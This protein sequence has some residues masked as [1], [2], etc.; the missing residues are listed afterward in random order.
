MLG[1]FGIPEKRDGNPFGEDLSIVQRVAVLGTE[2]NRLQN[3]VNNLART[4]GMPERGN[5]DPVQVEEFGR[6]I[7]EEV[8]AGRALTQQITSALQPIM[9]WYQS[10][11]Q[12]LRPLPDI[13]ADVVGDLKGDRSD[14][15]FLQKKLREQQREGQLSDDSD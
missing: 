12:H 14:L 10:E 1:N 9:D 11:E 4:L 15:L 7:L 13:V 2:R 6:R 5:Y 3:A 8:V